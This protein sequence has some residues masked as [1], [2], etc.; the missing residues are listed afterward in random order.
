MT[1]RYPESP[2]N[3]SNEITKPSAEFRQE[4]F[5]VLGSIILFIATYFVLVIAGLIVAALCVLAAYLIVSTVLNIWLIIFSIG[6]VVMAILIIFFLFKFIV[7]KTSVDRSGKTEIKRDDHPLLFEF[8]ARVAS[9]THTPLPRKVFISSEVNAYVFYDSTFWSMFLPIRKNLNIGLGLVNSVSLSEFKAILA[10]EFGHF[11]QRSMKLNSYVYHVNHIIHNMLFDNKGYGETLQ[12]FAELHWAFNLVATMTYGVIRS[13]QFALE[14]VYGI[15]RRR[16]MALSRQME[17]HA[18]AVA[19]S[20]SGSA[21][22]VRALYR[23]EYAESCYQQVLHIYN[24]WI[25]ENRKGL[26]LFAHHTSYMNE[27]ASD[28]KLRMEHGFVQVGAPDVRKHHR[29]RVVVKDQW[30]SHPSTEDREAHLLSLGIEAPEVNDSAWLLFSNLDKFQQVATNALYSEVKFQQSP[31]LIDGHAFEL[32]TREQAKKYSFHP[33]Y[34]GFY[35]NRDITPF[36]PD[37]LLK[38]SPSVP[39]SLAEILTPEVLTLQ[40]DMG[41]L[42]ADIQMLVAISS[43]DSGIDTFDF[44]GKKYAQAD[45]AALLETLRNEKESIIA[46]LDKADQQIFLLYHNH[47]S[48]LGRPNEAIAAYKEMFSICPE[49]HKRINSLSN[50]LQKCSILYD[51]SVHL[52]YVRVAV[53]DMFRYRRETQ[54]EVASIIDDEHYQVYFTTEDKQTFKEFGSDDR[55]FRVGKAIHQESVALYGNALA[56]YQRILID[57]CFDLKKHVLEEQIKM[58]GVE[59]PVEI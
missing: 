8:I 21:P 32:I 6:L 14:K 51:P 11:S 59:S 4:V 39:N 26:N 42:E 20:V 33:V 16:S 41:G 7:K 5:G 34:M 9:E 46:R 18:D 47:A 37:E 12:G 49:L 28:L 56:A 58:I 57:R 40:T 43:E 38:S 27:L 15:V 23:L 30:A 2:Q 35:D 53:N 48:H 25:S 22:L 55:D 24:R 31:E 3:V 29:T 44:D 1:Y 10:H 45:S 19:A 13:I 50:G 54:A 36:N 52:D 17:F